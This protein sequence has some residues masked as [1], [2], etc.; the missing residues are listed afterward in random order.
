MPSGVQTVLQKKSQAT[1]TSI[2][3]AMDLRHGVW[4]PLGARHSGSGMIFSST[5][6]QRAEPWLALTASFCV[7]STNQL[8]EFANDPPH[9]PDRP[10][11]F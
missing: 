4:T 3:T 5:R 10:P 11:R 1:I 8:F 7:R 9:A 2:C 6:P